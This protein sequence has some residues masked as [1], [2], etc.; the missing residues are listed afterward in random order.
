MPDA[1]CLAFVNPAL[2]GQDLPSWLG[3]IYWVLSTVCLVVAAGLACLGLS[4]CPL[5]LI[6]ESAAVSTHVKG[7]WSGNRVDS[8]RKRAPLPHDTIYRALYHPPFSPYSAP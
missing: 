7:T 8:E 5:D 3:S 2:T 1:T 6:Y 4:T